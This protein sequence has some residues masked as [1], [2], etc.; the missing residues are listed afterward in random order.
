MHPGVWLSASCPAPRARR[1]ET[2]HTVTDNV[3]LA[4]TQPISH[5]TRQQA[6][7]DR[8]G[9][10]FLHQTFGIRGTWP[11]YH[12]HPSNKLRGLS[13]DTSASISPL[14]CISRRRASFSWMYFGTCLLL[15][16]VASMSFLSV[17]RGSSHAAGRT[18]LSAGEQAAGIPKRSG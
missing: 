7:I 13:S 15:P 16:G 5:Y 9:V 12:F 3:Q 17:S 6:A 2:A 10:G 14:L 8:V 18:A 1:R 11:L 4:Q